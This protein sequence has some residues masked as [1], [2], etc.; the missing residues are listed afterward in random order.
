MSRAE[1][2]HRMCVVSLQGG[3]IRSQCAGVRGMRRP[4]QGK[5]WGPYSRLSKVRPQGFDLPS[6]CRWQWDEVADSAVT[7]SSQQAL[8]VCEG[9]RRHRRHR[10]CGT[11][12]IFHRGEGG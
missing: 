11:C 2:A 4:T 9:R 8:P 1:E 10:F 3:Q 12:K 7:Q 5:V 6:G